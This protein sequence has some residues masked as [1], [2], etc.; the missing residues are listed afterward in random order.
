FHHVLVN[1]SLMPNQLGYGT[2]ENDQCCT[3]IH[4][5]ESPALQE[6]EEK[7]HTLDRNTLLYLESSSMLLTDTITHK[8]LD[9]NFAK[10]IQIIRLCNHET[11][12]W[13]HNL[14]IV[15]VPEMVEE[16]KEFIRASYIRDM[17][18]DRKLQGDTYFTQF[19]GLHQIPEILTSEIN[20]YIE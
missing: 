8:S 12:I 9:D 15:T 17:V 5:S 4:L 10:L 11:T 1:I 13:E 2:S 7:L 19:R 16:Y 20:D 6:Y 18:Y 14:S 3:V